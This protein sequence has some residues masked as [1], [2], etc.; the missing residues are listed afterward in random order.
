MSYLTLLTPS[1][2]TG[3]KYL[4][5]QKKSGGKNKNPKKVGAKLILEIKLEAKMKLSLFY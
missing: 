3:Q 2:K 4:S 5:V 1:S